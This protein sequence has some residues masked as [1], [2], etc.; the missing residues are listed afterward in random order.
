MNGVEI[1][2]DVPDFFEFIDPDNDLLCYVTENYLSAI[3]LKLPVSIFTL[4][5]FPL[6][7]GAQILKHI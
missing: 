2:Y 3:D 5:S 1:R 4:I 6:G 7:L